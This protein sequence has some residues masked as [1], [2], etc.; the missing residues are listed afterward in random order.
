MNISSW[1]LYIERWL[2]STNAKDIG[3]MYLIFSVFAGLIGT[4]LSALIRLEL[5]G[6][7]VQF[8]ANTQLYNTIIT[9]HAVV[10]IF[11]MVMPSL[12][13]GFA[14]YLIP[15]M[16]GTVDTAFPRLNNISFWLLPPSLLLLIFSSLI[17][18]GA[19]TGWTLYPPLSGNASHSGVSVDLAIFA[20]HLSGISSLLGAINLITTLALLRSPGITLHKLHLFGWAVAIT[21]V[22]LLLSLPVLASGLTML[23]TDRNLNT[24]FFEVSGG[25]D[26]ILF[27]HLFL[28]LSLLS[29]F[30]LSVL[31]L[32]LITHSLCSS[33]FSLELFYAKFTKYYPSATLPDEEF[34]IWLIGFTEGDGCFTL[35]SRGEASFVI[36]QSTI[37]VQVLNMIKEKLGFGSV[38]VQSVRSR[39]SRYVVNKKR[40]IELLILLFNGNLILPSRKAQLEQFIIGFNKYAS[41]GTIILDSITYIST[42]IL[43]SLNNSWLAGFIDAEGCFSCSLSNLTNGYSIVFCVAQKWE[44]NMHIL[45]HLCVL[46]NAGTVVKH[47][48]DHVF[49]F[50]ISGLIKYAIVFYYFD[51]HT[52]RTKKAVS[53]KVWKEVHAELVNKNHLDPEKRQKLREKTYRINNTKKI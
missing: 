3:L 22:L 40:E 46:F 30:K 41:R 8:I 12:I 11:F 17:E 31:I 25:G 7:G 34:L 43:P 48:E 35:N 5:S 10:M 20:L 23:L 4:A 53:Y 27:Q 32:S 13:G 33:T 47:F 37:D 14:N 45:Q 39:T 16:I 6:P 1:G 28:A 24:T 15:L 49:E 51:T 52:L 36:T 18:G 26:P 38:I 42:S 29:Y 21:A 44:K 19:G 50:R 9:S 2:N